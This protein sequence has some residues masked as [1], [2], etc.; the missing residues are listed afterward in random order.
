MAGVPVSESIHPFSPKDL[1]LPDYVPMVLSE[2]TI[3]GV[4]GGVSLLVI[5]FVWILAGNQLNSGHF[6]LN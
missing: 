1:I 2:S 5:S 6:S 3:L 4:Y